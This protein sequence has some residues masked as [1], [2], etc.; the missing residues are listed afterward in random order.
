MKRARD[1][2]MARDP[3]YFWLDHRSR[4]QDTSTIMP[5]H[6]ADRP[7]RQD[8]NDNRDY[9]SDLRSS[10]PGKH[11]DRRRHHHHHHRH[12]GRRSRSPLRRGHHDRQVIRLQE[13]VE[14][15]Y[16]A[17]KLSRQDLLTYHN[18]FALYLDIQKQLVLQEL[19]ERDLIGRWKSFLGRW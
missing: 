11:S 15:P 7:A 3:N 13:A 9:Q 19:S 4:R 1:L 5:N 6:R 8:S 17:P 18:L 16:G 12:H 10:S 14:L 2:N